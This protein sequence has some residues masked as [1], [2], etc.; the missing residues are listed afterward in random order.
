MWITANF[1]S[2]MNSL[3]AHTSDATLL[4]LTVV[5]DIRALVGHGPFTTSPSCVLRRPCI[6]AGTSTALGALTL[7][8]RRT[9]ERCGVHAASP[10]A[11]SF[12]GAQC[13]S[14]V[15]VCLI[16]LIPLRF[17]LT[18]GAQYHDERPMV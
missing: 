12:D 10:V 11:L 17:S 8:L 6:A 18:D 7:Y 3:R 5:G 1:P 16:I 15:S 4:L 13:S 9:T 14:C 2:F